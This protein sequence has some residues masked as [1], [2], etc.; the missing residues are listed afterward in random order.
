[1]P[2]PFVGDD[3]EAVRDDAAQL[4]A[5]L[6]Q[7]RSLASVVPWALEL[8]EREPLL[9]AAQFPGDLLRGLMEVP[10]RF[11]SRNPALYR[12]HR[13][14]L[15]AAAALRRTMPPDERMSFWEPLDPALSRGAA[16]RTFD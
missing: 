11:W 7:G 14:A 10:D 2:D 13:T 16:S 6:V 3:R 1:M 15:R 9:R 4:L 8:V 12:R 5:S